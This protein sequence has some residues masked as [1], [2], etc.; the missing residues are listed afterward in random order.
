MKKEESN[1]PRL[2]QQFLN[3]DE[4]LSD[5]GSE[6]MVVVEHQEWVADRKRHAFCILHNSAVM[7]IMLLKWN[8]E[9]ETGFFT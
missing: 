2:R 1:L 4:A 6:E 3:V 9:I 5:K 7:N 8:T